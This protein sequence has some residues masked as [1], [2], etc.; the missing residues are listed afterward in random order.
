MRLRDLSKISEYKT[1]E[2][3]EFFLGIALR[4]SIKV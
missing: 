2:M 4:F 3:S 1:L